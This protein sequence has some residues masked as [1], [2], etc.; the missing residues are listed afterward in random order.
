M[1]IKIGGI[2]VKYKILIIDDYYTDRKTVYS[3]F[4]EKI[5][6][7]DT[8]NLCF[9][10]SHLDTPKSMEG[11]IR[12]INADAILIDAV[13][14]N[15]ITWKKVE[16][17]TVLDKIK[18]AYNNCIPPIF[19]I[20][21][22]WDEELIGTVNDAFAESLPNVLPKKYY[23]YSFMSSKVVEAETIDVTT[24]KINCEGLVNE[25]NKIHKMIAKHYGRTDKKLY[26]KNEINIL[27]IS[28][29]QYGDKKTTDNFI[30]LFENMQHSLKEN[31]IDNID[32]IVISGDV[33]MHGKENEYKEARQIKNLFKNF[34]P[35]ENTD[36]SDRVILAPGNHDFDINF[37]LLNYFSAKNL[38]D[39]REIDKLSIIKELLKEQAT[40]KFPYNKYG[41]SEFRRF[42]YDITHNSVYIDNENMNFII[43]DFL[44]WG[45]RFIVLNSI[46]KININETNRVDF[47]KD[48]I[49]QI[50][51]K[52]NDSQYENKIFNIVI[53]HHTELFLEEMSTENDL[54]QVFNQLKNSL[55]CRLFLGGHRHIN[56]DK[57]GKTSNDEKYTVIEASTLRIDEKDDKYQRGFNV[58]Q[59][60]K[61]DENVNK[62]IEKQFVFD[63]G[64]GAIKLASTK[65]HE[66]NT[67]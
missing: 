50:I 28:D 49:N 60:I 6:N 61:T 65:N 20:S 7:E 19:L 4:F 1:L 37:C 45:I 24:S 30:G 13:L 16:I 48:E 2:V 43:D 29:L 59:L 46:S 58:L 67:T 8:E 55:K 32:L 38:H 34:W 11:K 36:Y 63:K 52:I 22:F 25:R 35:N 10:I 39:K 62:V 23:T 51:Q 64:D 14:N 3:S 31:N 66:F 40:N 15:E 18:A 5:Y 44:D 56:D 57:D 33:A 27:H 12:N 26:K 21:A 53:S 41:T 54:I 9:E 47:F 17:E 42:C